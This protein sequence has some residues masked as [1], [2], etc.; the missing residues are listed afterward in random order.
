VR[1]DAA[2]RARRRSPCLAA[3]ARRRR[4]ARSPRARAFASLVG[5]RY[6]PVEPV[7]ACSAITQHIFQSVAPGAD[8]E[9][10]T[11]HAYEVRRRVARDRHP[12]PERDE[13]ASRAWPRRPCGPGGRPT[14]RARTSRSGPWPLRQQLRAEGIRRSAPPARAENH[15][16]GGRARASARRGA[17]P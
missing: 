17:A 8:S 13:S 7:V 3:P 9:R 12:S 14:A 16:A 15:S 11:A 5:V 2:G 4:Y 10:R 6:G 1:I